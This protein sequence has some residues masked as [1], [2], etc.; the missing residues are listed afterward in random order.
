MT[1]GRSRRGEEGQV[2]PALLLAVIGSFAIAVAFLGLQN[3]LD[4]GSRAASAS[5]AAALAVGTGFRDQTLESIGLLGDPTLG[6]VLSLL[7]NQG[8]WPG[9]NEVAERY[10]SANGASLEGPVQYDGFDLG[11]ARW[12][13]EV[14]TRQSDAVKGG[15]RTA[16][17]KSTSKVAVELTS[18]CTGAAGGLGLVVGGSCIGP[19]EWAEGCTAPEPPE[20]PEPTATPTGTDTPSPSPSPTPTFTPSPF[21]DASLPDLLRWHIHLIA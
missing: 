10:A 13:F 11:R 5:D 15:D 7:R 17:S 4:Q 12:T 14:T 20:P 2:Y 16:H 1:R 18:L 3:V 6:G 21:C 8:D 9:A 19:Q